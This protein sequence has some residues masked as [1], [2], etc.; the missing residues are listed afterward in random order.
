MSAVRA[1]QYR[2]IVPSERIVQT[3]E[4]NVYDPGTCAGVAGAACGT[5]SGARM[6]AP[7]DGACAV[8]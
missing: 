5:G 6:R 2:E 7:A 4:W 3:F 8:G 1:C